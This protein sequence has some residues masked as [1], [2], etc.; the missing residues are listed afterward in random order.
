MGNRSCVDFGPLAHRV[1][2]SQEDPLDFE[3]SCE[4]LCK[5]CR[6]EAGAIKSQSESKKGFDTV[7]GWTV[8]YQCNGRSDWQE[9][10]CVLL[11]IAMDKYESQQP[12]VAALPDGV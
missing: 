10:K 9:Y 7:D 11:I 4:E 5:R 8:Q 3:Q 12:A 1:W 6:S 2:I